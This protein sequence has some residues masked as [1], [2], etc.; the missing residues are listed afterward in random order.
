MKNFL[1]IRL[2]ESGVGSKVGLIVVLRG[3]ALYGALGFLGGGLG[4]VWF[5]ILFLQNIIS[6]LDLDNNEMHGSEADKSIW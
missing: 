1:G 2:L 4:L 6:T 3:M 5:L